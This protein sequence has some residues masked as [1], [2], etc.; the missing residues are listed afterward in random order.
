MIGTTDKSTENNTEWRK[1]DQMGKIRRDMDKYG[2]TRKI[3]AN[4]ENTGKRKKYRQTG[5][6][7]KRGKYRLTKNKVECMTNRCG[8]R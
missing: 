8:Y 2:Q 3:Q 7:Y 6:R 1:Y 5:R 4:K